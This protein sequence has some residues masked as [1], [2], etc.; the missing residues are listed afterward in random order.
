M[1]RN[2]LYKARTFLMNSLRGRYGADQLGKALVW[3][4][5]ALLVLNMLFPNLVFY[6]LSL[7]V[8]SWSIFRM[9][10]RQTAK[11][12]RENQVYLGLMNKAKKAVLQLKNRLKDRK[13]HRYRACPS[14]KTAL[15]LP[16]KI[17]V[18][19]VK[20]PVCQNQFEV[21]IRR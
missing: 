19:K 13:T 20:C 6:I 2:L 7:L 16:I 4:M 5:L 10:S 12:A 9:Y 17:G 3:L 1:I 14:C 15:R 18:N 8:A 11:R 21:N